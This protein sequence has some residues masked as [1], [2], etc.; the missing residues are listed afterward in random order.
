MVK[1]R[2]FKSNNLPLWESFSGL[3][4]VE[5]YKKEALIEGKFIK[6]LFTFKIRTQ[7]PSHLIAM[8]FFGLVIFGFMLI[9]IF[10]SITEQIFSYINLEFLIYTIFFYLI[11]TFSF[12]IGLA[13]VINFIINMKKILVLN[14]NNSSSIN[15]NTQYKKTVKKK[16]PKRRK[17]YK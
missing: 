17:D 9:A 3:D 12:F 5:T 1:K 6:K 16:H 2:S 10:G 14:D 7:R 15:M 8:I 4:P 13:L 11:I